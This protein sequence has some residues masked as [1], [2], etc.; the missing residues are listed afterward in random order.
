MS[1]YHCPLCP[2]IFQYRTEADWHLREEHRSRTTEAADLRAELAAATRP[3]DWKRL[4]ELRVRR[5]GPAI[6]L[7]LRTA[8]AATMSVLDIARLRQLAERARRALTAQP[9]RDTVV[10]VVAD[11]LFKAVSAAETQPT[12]RGVA[13]LVDKDDMA[14][15]HLPFAPRDREVVGCRFATRDLDYA[16]RR[17]PSYRVIV[18][19]RNPR[20][21]EGH[22]RDLSEAGVPARLGGPRSVPP[23][24]AA[25]ALSSDELLEERIEAA[26]GLPLVVVGDRKSIERFSRE[27]AHAGEVVA[28]IARSR[29][30]R[31]NLANHI[32]EHLDRLY[33]ESQSRA[34]AE[35]VQAERRSSIVWGIEAAWESVSSGTADRMWVEHDYAVGPRA[36]ETKGAP[37]EGG[38]PWS[39]ESDDLVEALLVKAARRGIETHLLAPRTLGRADPVAVKV[40]TSASPL[41]PNPL[42]MASI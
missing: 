25:P 32:T 14:I 30:H 21:L 9:H 13:V 38:S 6:T 5:P 26:G 23:A 42:H 16:L 24:G 22:V 28:E 1:V 11:R 3:L 40:P 8:P 17:Y 20:I 18:L 10:S 29:F 34:V 36:A 27:S 7:L 31:D 41:W 2:L 35:L 39:A 37:T 4:A 15:V 12:D 33:Y 19:G